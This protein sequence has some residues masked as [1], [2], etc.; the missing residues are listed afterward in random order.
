M[1]KNESIHAGSPD[2]FV[3]GMSSDVTSWELP[4]QTSLSQNRL[5]LSSDI[6]TMSNS[7][8]SQELN[9]ACKSLVLIIHVYPYSIG[10]ALLLFFYSNTLFLVE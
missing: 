8:H 3:T 10:V 4:S 6:F 2:I 5:G 7:N 1:G 9:N